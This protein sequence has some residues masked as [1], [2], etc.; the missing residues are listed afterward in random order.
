MREAEVEACGEERAEL[1]GR[2]GGLVRE[3]AEE[4]RRRQ[5]RVAEGVAEVVLE[6]LGDEAAA[7][8]RRAHH[9]PRRERLEEAEALQHERR[10]AVVPPVDDGRRRRGAGR[11]RRRR[12]AGEGVVVG[13]RGGARLRAGGGALHVAEELE[14][15]GVEDL[16]RARERL[17]RALRL[18][19]VEHREQGD[20]AVDPQRGQDRQRRHQRLGAHTHTRRIR[21][22]AA[23]A[24][25]RAGAAARG[26]GGAVVELREEAFEGH[27]VG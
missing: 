10:R 5:L 25:R 21:R 1:G 22:A 3:G 9:R 23:A 20:L 12:A 17:V 6:E 26:G 7:E 15:C 11:R 4:A 8:E 16:R 14:A 18:A 13:G 19:A 27:L 24:A 2:V